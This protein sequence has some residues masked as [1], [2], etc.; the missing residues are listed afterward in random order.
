MNDQLGDPTDDL[1]VVLPS[2]GK[3]IPGK[4]AIDTDPDVR[5][6]R[7]G[8]KTLSTNAVLAHLHTS[9]C[10][11]L[12]AAYFAYRSTSLTLLRKGTDGTCGLLAPDAVVITEELRSF[13]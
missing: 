1:V 3:R 12:L 6:L 9:T 13:L 4:I 7:T 2:A 10:T 11:L 5:A 8:W